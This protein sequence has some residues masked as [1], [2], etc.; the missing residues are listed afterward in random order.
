MKESVVYVARCHTCRRVK[1]DHLKRAGPLQPMFIL[2]WKWK[3]I[4]ID[5]IIGLPPTQKGFD[6]KG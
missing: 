2:G 4:S 3:E 1:A 5:F 6:S